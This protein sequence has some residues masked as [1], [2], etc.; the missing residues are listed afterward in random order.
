M[1]TSDLVIER[2]DLGGIVHECIKK[3]GV[4]F[5][6]KKLSVDIS[7]IDFIVL[8]DRRWLLFILEQIISNAIKY[9]A[10]GGI[11]VYMQGR[12][13]VI[14]DSGIGIRTEDLPRIFSKGYTGYNGRLDS[15]AS[16]VGLY[17]AKKAAYA[18]KIA[19]RVESA[20]GRGTKALLSFPN[21]DTEIFR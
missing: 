3:F 14:E 6:Y 15:R 4:L 11:R 2:C 19:I 18:L 7:P 10:K 13:L 21:P 16:G 17:L 9:T 12:Q 8:S 5:I 20:V 1:R